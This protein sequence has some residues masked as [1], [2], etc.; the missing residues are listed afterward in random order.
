MT[1]SSSAHP[2][3]LGVP[4][5]RHLPRF[6]VIDIETSGLSVQRHRILQVAVVT[7]EDG[8]IVDE[9]S[10]LIGLRWPFQPLGPRRVHGIRRRDLRGA[11]SER[12]VL[13]EFARRIGST[14]VVAHNTSFDWPFLE[15][16][17]ETAGVELPDV[18]RLCTL[19]ASR[20]L[21][22]QRRTSHRLTDVAER[23]G[24][25]NDRPHDALHDARTTASVLPLLLAD[26]GITDE[27]G[28]RRL[29]DRR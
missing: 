20:R 3:A 2:P 28:L 1:E 14:V 18:E 25:T 17:A 6:S 12:H 16:A 7:V 26:H 27:A 11:P 21:D 4:H 15:R 19:W 9:W 22:P 29:Y 5:G 10:S 13:E 24:V 8:R 23:Y